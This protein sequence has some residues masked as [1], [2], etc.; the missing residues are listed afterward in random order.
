MD[1]KELVAGIKEEFEKIGSVTEKRLGEIEK[2]LKGFVSAETVEAQIAALKAS[3]ATNRD[4]KFT[5]PDGKQ[6]DKSWEANAKRFVTAVVDKNQSE[7][8]ALNTQVGSEGGF[9]VPDEMAQDIIY[10]IEAPNH[11]LGKVTTVPIGS[12]SGEMP[13][14]GAA[15]SVFWKGQNTT[16]TESDPATEQIKWKVNAL[17]G[18]TRTSRELLADSRFNVVQYFDTLFA[19][20]FRKEIQ[21]KIINGT[22]SG[23]P[24][25]LHNQI[26]IGATGQLGA[27][28]AASD[29]IKVR[30]TLTEEY[31]QNAAWAIHGTV[32]SLIE[33]LIDLQGRFLYLDGLAPQAPGTLL[34]H[35]V[36]EIPQIPTTLGAGTES[37]IFLG[38]WSQ[39]FWFDRG[40]FGLETSTEAENAFVKHQLLMKMWGRWD[41]QVA[42]TDAFKKLT[43]VK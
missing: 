3:P 1:V 30:R 35:P 25:G 11:L 23:E 4:M 9:L 2:A 43:G 40:E 16:G 14:E 15:V 28:L 8:K 5:A 10:K 22:G 38:D 20:A 6:V 33:Q 7:L 19:K 13:R 34:G 39:Y 41:G 29:L 32:I 21:N 12:I 17:F 24:L 18:M 26:G 36:L 42:L 27:N 37:E 31:R